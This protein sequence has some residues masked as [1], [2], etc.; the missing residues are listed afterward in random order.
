MVLHEMDN[1][2]CRGSREMPNSGVFTADF[3]QMLPKPRQL[4]AVAPGRCLAH[5]LLALNA[6]PD[7]VNFCHNAA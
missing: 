6:V 2:A 5:V 4:E 7:M 3:G 1:P